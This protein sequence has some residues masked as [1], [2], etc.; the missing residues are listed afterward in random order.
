MLCRTLPALRSVQFEF[1]LDASDGDV[2]QL[3]EH[4]LCK[5]RVR[6]SSP[7]VSTNIVSLDSFDLAGDAGAIG[8]PGS[9][10]REHL[11]C[12]ARSYQVRRCT[13]GLC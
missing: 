12:A 1:R 3:G 4:L 13:T 10:T 5:Q 6:G 8:A 2:A 7:L 11:P 9:R